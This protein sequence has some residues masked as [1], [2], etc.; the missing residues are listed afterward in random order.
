MPLREGACRALAMNEYFLLPPC[1]TVSLTLGD[2]VAHIVNNSQIVRAKNSLKGLACPM[3]NHLPIGK[4]CI[5]RAENV[6]CEPVLLR[7]KYAS[8]RDLKMISCPPDQGHCEHVCI[9]TR[10]LA[11]MTR[12]P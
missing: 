4:S 2:V 3:S 1:H 8:R 10:C 9:A 6:C 11:S 12:M 7:M 5:P